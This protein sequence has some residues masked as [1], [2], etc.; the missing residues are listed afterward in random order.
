[1]RSIKI[2]DLTQAIAGPVCTQLLGGLGADIIKV[3]PPDGEP[4][5]NLYDGAHFAAVNL[6]GKRSIC[7]DMATKEGQKALYD[8][9]EGADVFV[10]NFRPDVKHRLGVDYETL[11]EQNEDL[12]YCSISGFGQE[13]PYSHFPGIDPVIQAISGIM[14]ATGYPERLPVRVGTPVID[15]TTGMMAAWL[16]VSALHNRGQTGEGEYIDVSL[17]DNAVF[18]M[19]QWIAHYSRTGQRPQRAGAGT[20]GLAPYGLFETSDGHLFLGVLNNKV[21]ERL[22]SQS[23]EMNCALMNGSR[24]RMLGGS[25]GINCVTN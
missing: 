22:C 3:E 9:L 20:N 14:D 15:Y 5:R 25:I 17:F 13:G 23:A 21:F 2:V 1:M 12:V 7:I 4:F 8:L 24:Q 10:E 16:I 11:S 19:S 6:G 18:L